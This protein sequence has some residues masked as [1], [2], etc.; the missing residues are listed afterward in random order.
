MSNNNSK[1]KMGTPTTEPFY[2]QNVVPKPGILSRTASWV[3]GAFTRKKKKKLNP[4]PKPKSNCVPYKPTGEQILKMEKRECYEKLQSYDTSHLMIPLNSLKDKIDFL[5]KK[6]SKNNTKKKGINNPEK[7]NNKSEEPT[8]DS[9]KISFIK[10]NKLFKYSVNV[11][12]SALK[13]MNT[14]V[15]P[16]RDADNCPEIGETSIGEPVENNYENAPP[17]ANVEPIPNNKKVLGNLPKANP[18]SLG[19]GKNFKIGGSAPNDDCADYIEL[20]S[21]VKQIID[22]IEK[23]QLAKSEMNAANENK[24]GKNS[25]FTTCKST[26]EI[27]TKLEEAR[28]KFDIILTKLNSDNRLPRN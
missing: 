13:R 21:Y 18:V 7:S 2:A 4:K 9:E 15:I 17:I 8:C 27:F 12:E 11:L 10:L 20:R 3:K 23:I 25:K 5:N 26:N 14:L 28:S 6:T 24:A 19:K 22:E 1:K 16:K